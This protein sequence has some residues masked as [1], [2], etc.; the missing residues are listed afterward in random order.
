MVGLLLLRA[1]QRESSYSE[2]WTSGLVFSVKPTSGPSVVSCL[3][4]FNAKKCKKKRNTE[5]NGVKCLACLKLRCSGLFRLRRKRNSPRP[6]GHQ[7]TPAMRAGS[8]C[9]CNHG[10]SR[11]GCR[12]A[13]CQERYHSVREEERESGH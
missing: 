4:L 12:C 10:Q 11:H 6:A 7:S 13:A 5:Q 3:S 1:T 9:G 8:C 2:S